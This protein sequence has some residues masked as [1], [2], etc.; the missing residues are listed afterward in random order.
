MCARSRATCKTADGEPV[1]FSIVANNYGIASSEVDR[2]SDA[3]LT[4]VA[5]FRR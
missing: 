4:A 1:V 3:V 2:V 5:Q